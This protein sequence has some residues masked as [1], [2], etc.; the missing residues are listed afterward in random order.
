MVT[1]TRHTLPA[2]RTGSTATALPSSVI[3]FTPE[4]GDTVCRFNLLLTNIKMGNLALYSYSYR[5]GPDYANGVK[6]VQFTL[7]SVTEY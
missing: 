7:E 3:D 4:S 1:S 5:Y 2:G 6:N